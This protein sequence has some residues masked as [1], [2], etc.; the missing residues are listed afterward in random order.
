VTHL[1]HG[2]RK[3]FP[4]ALLDM[5]M[6]HGMFRRDGPYDAQPTA[7]S[8]TASLDVARGRTWSRITR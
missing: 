8:D 3:H 1:R 2:R 4:A 6:R 7:S 5:A